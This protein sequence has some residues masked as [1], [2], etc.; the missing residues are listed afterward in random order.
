[1]AFCYTKRDKILE[2]EVHPNDPNYFV[3]GS[4][5]YIDFWLLEGNSI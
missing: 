3:T 4:F 5:K 2:I 1:M